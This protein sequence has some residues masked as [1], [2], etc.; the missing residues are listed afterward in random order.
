MLEPIHYFGLRAP[1][2]IMKVD[3]LRLAGLEKVGYEIIVSPRGV[4]NHTEIDCCFVDWS[5]MG[6][7]W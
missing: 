6:K 3:T 2:K 1:P 5:D 7:I 4:P